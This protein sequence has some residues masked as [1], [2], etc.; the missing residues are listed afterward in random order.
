[1]TLPTDFLCTRG[2]LL[3]L[4]LHTVAASTAF[5]SNSSTSSNTTS[6]VAALKD[7]AVT[8]IILTD[9]YYSVGNSFDPYMPG[10]ANG[11][12]NVSRYAAAVE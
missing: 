8:N 2:A 3:L 10:G 1:M 11:P 9:N 7:P 5:V 6:F 4:L 12:F